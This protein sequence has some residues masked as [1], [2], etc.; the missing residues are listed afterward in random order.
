MLKNQLILVGLWWILSSCQN[1]TQQAAGIA[2]SFD[3]R[4]ITQWDSLRPL[5]RKYN[6]KVTF[7]VTQFDSLTPPQIAVL[8][9]LKQ[10]GHE[11]GA[12][13]AAHHRIIDF[14]LAGGSLEDYFKQEVEAEIKS[15]QK[16]GFNPTS[17]AHVGGQQTWWTDR[18]LLRRYFKILRDVTT[19]KR[20]IGFLYWYRPVFALDEAF[21]EFDYCQTV[22]AI[23]IDNYTKTTDNE[24]FDGLIRARDTQSV[25]LMMG[26]KPLFTAQNE[27]YGFL[28]T[29]LEDILKQSQRLG[30][31]TYTMS[32]LVSHVKP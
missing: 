9:Q 14:A 11:I 2:L 1:A 20:Q 12:H 27:S 7:Y 26:H 18:I 21:Y 19:P 28:V 8:K 32:E 16:A 13:G 25:F 23:I 4:Y 6:A 22:N 31:K 30:L 15:M 3:D 24:I 10:E 17:F 5:L 29:R